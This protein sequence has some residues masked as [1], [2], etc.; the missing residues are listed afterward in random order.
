MILLLL[1]S[2][3]YGLLHGLLPDEHTWP[4]TFSYAIGNATGRQ[5]VRSG[6]YFSLAFTIQRAL[7]SELAYLLL[8]PWL[9]KEA[10]N[11]AVDLVVGA[12]M[13]LAGWY[14]I[15]NKKYPHLH[16]LGHHHEQSE[17]V[18][19]NRSVF[20]FLHHPSNGSRSDAIPT[21][22]AMIHGF[23]AGFG[24]GPFALF[25]YTTAAP[26]MSS[27]WTGFLP[28]LLFGLGTMVMLMILG[29]IFGTALRITRRF[30]ED[31]IRTIGFNTGSQTLLW[32]GLVFFL[33]GV[34]SFAELAFG[35]SVDIG[36]L[37]IALVMVGVALPVLSYSVWKVLHCRKT[38]PA[39]AASNPQ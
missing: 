28:G 13:A 3:G 24:F 38:G 7:A 9:T 25:I 34:Y 22:W 26:H 8:A 2:F 4:I 23:I 11:P 37:L 32:G 27:P 5:G 29:G 33:G 1:E 39:P 21:H 6:F 30:N 31:E 36:N 17:S 18:E 35:R 12:V 15:R 19:Q 16:F 20:S 14:I 10:T